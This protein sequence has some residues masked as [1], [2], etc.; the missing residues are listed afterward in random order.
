MIRKLSSARLVALTV[1]LTVGIGAGVA[2][3]TGPASALDS[4]VAPPPPVD[5]AQKASRLPS[6]LYRTHE[7][8][9]RTPKSESFRRSLERQGLRVREDGRLLV[10]ITGPL[11]GPPVSNAVLQSANG[12]VAQTWRSLTTV[13][14]D[15]VDL[16]ALATA[17]PAEYRVEPVLPVATDDVEGEGPAVTE[18]DEYRDAGFDGSGITI[19]VID[20]GYAGLALSQ[21]NGDAPGLLVA[22]D[23]T[24]TGMEATTRH[25]LGCLEAIYD[26]APG[27]TYRIYKVGSVT[28]V[29]LAVQNCIANDVDIISHSLS[30][31]NLGWNDNTG[32]AC[33]AAGSASDNHILFFT[34]AGNR[35]QQHWKGTFSDSDGDGVHQWSGTDETLNL[36]VGPDGGGSFY[37]SW[38]NS[39]TDLDLYLYD[40]SGTILA[41]STNSGGNFEAI[42]WA[43]PSLSSNL[44]INLRVVRASGPSTQF[45]VFN[46][47]RRG[48]N[49]LEHTVA[50]S[51]I[52]SPSNSTKPN[53]LSIAAVDRLNFGL[54]EGS[55]GVQMGYSSQGP[56]NGGANGT[57]FSGPTNTIGFTYSTRFG[58]TSCATPNAA[59][60]AAVLWSCDPS[61]PASK[62]RNH[63]IDWAANLKNW[64]PVGLDPI[65]GFGGIHIPTLGDCDSSGTND[66]CEI[67]SAVHD[68]DNGNGIPDVPV[69]EG[70]GFTYTIDPDLLYYQPIDGDLY[71]LARFRITQPPIDPAIVEMH[72][73]SVGLVH[74]PGV[75][76]PQE[77]LPGPALA[78]LQGGQGPAFFSTSFGTEGVTIGTVFDFGGSESFPAVQD[79]GPLVLI[80]YQFES[81]FLTGGFDS[82]EA[83]VD[84]SDDV[85][86]P[87]V[88]NVIAGP[89]GQAFTPNFDGGLIEVY[90]R[91]D[92]RFSIGD[93]V[94]TTQ[95]NGEIEVEFDDAGAGTLEIAI[96]A[97][98]E[99]SV[100]HATQGYAFEVAHDPNY[101]FLTGI[102]LP[103]WA[104]AL[105]GG[106]GP[107]FVAID[108]PGVGPAS[109]AVT[110]GGSATRLFGTPTEL[111]TLHYETNA[112]TLEGSDGAFTS[113]YFTDIL[114]SDDN[115]V[116]AGGLS[117]APDTCG[118]NLHLRPATAGGPEF[119]RGDCNTDGSIAISDAVFGLGYLFVIGSDAPTCDDACDFNDNGA[120]DIADMVAVLNYLFVAG[121]SAPP[122]PVDACGVD[123]TD[124]ALG[125]DSSPCP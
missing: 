61:Q 98:E 83:S 52:T 35:A 97:H 82:W 59:G 50:P 89:G 66:I 23:Y 63:L 101:L 47:A 60:V 5:P 24:G 93:D 118:A 114:G 119:R 16:G 13:W 57:D 7:A 46:H 22:T 85:G 25:G 49:W 108:D 32:A 6:V 62:V 92:F 68:D 4:N 76:Y 64:G 19:A 87:P 121:S 14:I 81:Q 120:V 103:A 115:R 107:D 106:A 117:F 77:V 105:H 125:C 112:D 26:H 27:A 48:V 18:S 29:G 15:P 102:E 67:V 71:W 2:A 111:G 43:N 40:S 104:Q 100:L 95:P 39:S 113:L 30:W 124:D 33:A 94:C 79:I 65:Y 1:A 51:S 70:T 42:F 123:P 91:N 20:S 75:L 36:T 55:T 10:E 122:P 8:S 17:L 41:Q 73:F 99:S 3:Q 69:C 11:D 96:I 34:S 45:E 86:N 80:G 74:P 56:S 88:E 44:N 90:P 9:A 116:Q 21:G 12:E 53:V 58:G 28:D 78:S 54:P 109:V 72:G 38:A 84:F 31:Y 37:L 110:Y